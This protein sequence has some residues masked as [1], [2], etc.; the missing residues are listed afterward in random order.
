VVIIKELLS[1]MPKG[2]LDVESGIHG[3][4]I[5]A[6]SFRGHLE[7]CIFLTDQN[8][9]FKCLASLLYS[10]CVSSEQRTHENTVCLSLSIAN[11]NKVV[12]ILLEKEVDVNLGMRGESPLEAATVEGH[13]EVV[14]LLEKHGAVRTREVAWSLT[15]RGRLAVKN[16]DVDAKTIAR[17]NTLKEEKYEEPDTD[18]GFA[19][20]GERS[21]LDPEPY[22]ALSLDE[23]AGS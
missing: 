16:S 6:A 8:S 23:K 14:E 18:K 9:S 2:E 17:V 22:G 5:Y 15:F 3:T 7:V 4:P 21:L 11:S 13:R 19:T 1:R 20:A 10:P 12:K